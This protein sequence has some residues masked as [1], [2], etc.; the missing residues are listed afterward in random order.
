MSQIIHMSEINPTNPISYIYIYAARHLNETLA[1]KT[2]SFRRCLDLSGAVPCHPYSHLESLESFWNHLG[3]SQRRLDFV[4]DELYPRPRANSHV[5][6]GHYRLQCYP[7]RALHGSSRCLELSR[8]VQ[9]CP[10]VPEFSSDFQDNSLSG[11][12]PST[13]SYGNAQ[14]HRSRVLV[15]LDF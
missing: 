10:D 7:T 8:V 9:S 6:E 2:A 5:L 4:C 12:E 11:L 14:M 15:V 13:M 1:C 3:S